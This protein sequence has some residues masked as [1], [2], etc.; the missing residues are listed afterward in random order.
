[1]FLCALQVAPTFYIYK[2]GVKAA[3][4]TG[5]KLDRLRALFDEA[6]HQG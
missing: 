6:I 3:E 2:G 1:M 5:A 4:M